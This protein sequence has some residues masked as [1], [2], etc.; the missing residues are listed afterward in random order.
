MTERISA[1]MGTQT[2]DVIEWSRSLRSRSPSPSRQNV[3]SRSP[4]PSRPSTDRVI[5][6]WRR[7]DMDIGNYLTDVQKSMPDFTFKKTKSTNKMRKSTGS[8]AAN[9]NSTS[10]SNQKS[11]SNLANLDNIEAEYIKNLQQ[12]IYFLE[13]ESNYL[14]DQAKKA[15]EMHPKMT[16]EAERM[17]TKLRTM[18]LEIDSLQMEIKKKETIIAV[19]NTE[20][21]KTF[22]RLHDEEAARSRDKRNLMDEIIELKKEKDM[23]D[24][25]LNQKDSQ[26][27]DAKTELDKSATALKNAE[28]K[29]QSLRSQLEQRGEQHNLTQITL[30]E[31]RSELLSVQTQLRELEDK[32]YNNTLQIQDKVA[33]DLKD[34]IRLLRQNLKETEMTAEHDRYMKSKLTDDNANLVRENAL[35]TQQLGDLQKEVERER[36][37]RQTTE[38]RHTQSHSELIQLRDREKDAKFEISHLQEQLR[39][40]QEKSRHYLENLTKTESSTTTTELQLKT[41]KSRVSE[42]ESFQ[43][44]VERECEQ[45]RKDKLLLVDHVSEIQR[46][47][48]SKEQEIMLLRSQNQTMEGK[49]RDTDR[50]SMM[51][52]SMQSQKWEEFEKLAESMRSLSHT[53][54]HTGSS[55]TRIQ[56]Y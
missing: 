50:M 11:K 44:A 16:A 54:S 6:N 5:G 21:E 36:G 30:D 40:E 4:S 51:E 49:L 3:R 56:Q 14:R 24:R 15:T 52:S 43:H 45:L 19:T 9:F 37:A 39:K 12:Q 22:E 25:E 32:Y 18:Q 38:S 55:T 41:V 42:L 48:E 13:L 2:A 8:L 26:L 29:I 1:P 34:E 33:N 31:K 17:L 35:L 23:M 7:S 28:I 46:K 27:F 10:T 53:M 47:L 20:K